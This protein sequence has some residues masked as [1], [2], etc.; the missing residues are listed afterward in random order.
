MNGPCVISLFAVH[1]QRSLTF[2]NRLS[3]RLVIVPATNLKMESS[4]K[5]EIDDKIV[6]ICIDYIS[7]GSPQY[8]KVS[9]GVLKVK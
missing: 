7:R 1:P 8:I 2:Y 4:R 5:V 6:I 3:I 9:V